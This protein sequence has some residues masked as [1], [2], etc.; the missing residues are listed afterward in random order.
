ML[1]LLGF[2]GYFI[3][4]LV[5]APKMPSLISA[6][7]VTMLILFNV[8]QMVYVI[9]ISQNVSGVDLLLYV[10]RVNILILSAFVIRKQMVEQM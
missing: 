3:L 6:M 5:D 4:L 7:S 9:Q 8:F 2:T 1:I 10:Y